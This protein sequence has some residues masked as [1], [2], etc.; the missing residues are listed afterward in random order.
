MNADERSAILHALDRIPASAWRDFLGR[1][2]AEALRAH[3]SAMRAALDAMNRPCPDTAR[4]YVEDAVDVLGQQIL[5]DAQM[6]PW[7][8]EQLLRELASTK[9]DRLAERYR[10]LAGESA[11]PLHRNATQGGTGSST[12]ASYWRRGG[13]WARAFCEA[14]DLP[15]SLADAQSRGRLDDEQVE[16]TIVLND[17]H[18]FQTEV[19]RKLRKLLAQGAGEAALLSLPTGAGKTRVAVEALCDHLAAQTRERRPRDVVLWIAQSEELLV[20]AWNCFRQVWQSRRGVPRT[21]ALALLRAWGGRRRDDIEMDDGPTVVL[22]T[23]QQLHAWISGTDSDLSDVIPA[24]RHAVT[25]IDEAHGAVAPSYGEVLVALGQRAKH[26][27]QTRANAPPVVGLSATPWRADHDEDQRL[28]HFFHKQLLTPNALGAHPIAALQARGILSKVRAESLALGKAPAL[29]DAEL[30]HVSK[31]HELPGGYLQRLGREPG[32]NAKIIE[33]LLECGDDARA[34]VFACSVEHAELLATLL[35]R[36]AGAEV[37]AVVTGQTPRAQRA[38]AIE[39]FRAGEL[40]YLC[41]MSVLTTGFDAPKANVVC[42]TRPT[43]SAAL[44]EQM[45]GRGLRGRH[46]GGTARCL[47]LDAQ[48][49]GLPLRIQS[50]ARVRALWDGD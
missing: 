42:V 13:H 7:L 16:P 1:D 17:L 11:A 19:Y 5:C 12:M 35:N 40:R 38:I 48:D 45:V 44:Y 6:G 31:F 20:Q 26:H 14:F 33:R 3:R 32:R 27:W 30:K 22:A 47:V 18:D 15:A 41:N 46:N 39:R 29:N 28:Q 34:L 23:I 10:E 2:E 4:S 9:W 25:L 8:R 50:Y 43:A 37:A 49:D 36:V 21:N 24:S